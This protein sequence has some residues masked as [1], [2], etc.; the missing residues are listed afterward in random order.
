MEMACLWRKEVCI[1]LVNT[2]I[3]ELA[4]KRISKKVYLG[5]TWPLAQAQAA[6]V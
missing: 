1:G 6:G 5:V 2:I 4:Q 3:N